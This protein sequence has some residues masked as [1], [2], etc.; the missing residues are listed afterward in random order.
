MLN[1][2]VGANDGLVD[3]GRKLAPNALGAEVASSQDKDL[4]AVKCLIG[5]L[6]GLLSGLLG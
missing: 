1:L 4:K 2:A 5:L 3:R 6:I